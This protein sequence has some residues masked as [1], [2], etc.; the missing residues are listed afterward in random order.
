MWVFF[1]ISGGINMNSLEGKIAFTSGG[2]GIN[3]ATI[4][5]ITN[6]IKDIFK[7]H[8]I[9]VEPQFS[10]D[11]DSIIFTKD[12]PMGWPLSES[13]RYEIMIT[14]RE[15]K[16]YKKVLDMGETPCGYPSWSPDGAKIAF[17][18]GEMWDSGGE[19]YTAS[20]D[21]SNIKKVTDLKTFACRPA[22]TTDGK[23]I[24]F[25]SID[26]R[27]YSINYDGTDLKQIAKGVESSISPDGKKLVFR[28]PW[29]I[30][31]CDING[32]NKKLLVWNYNRAF[33]FRDYNYPANLTWSPDGRYLLY[34]RVSWG[35]WEIF[36][37][38]MVVSVD[39]PFKKV[40]LNY[41]PGGRL[42][43]ISWAKK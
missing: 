10:P 22:W 28:G 11:G 9:A 43:G 32:K 25:T 34:S 35:L 6:S 37:D 26:K 2:G 8:I 39:N 30:Y 21:G 7:E 38:M 42:Q 13:P 27:I 5:N 24:V 41:I 40:Q 1:N 14:D 31:L 15:G 36:A 18:A 17:L 3:I 19:L 20:I 23:R 12:N 33:F 16:N 4:N 29:S